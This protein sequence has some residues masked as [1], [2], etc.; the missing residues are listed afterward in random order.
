MADSLS[1]FFGRQPE[2][3]LDDC[4]REAIH[5]SC[6]VQDV[7]G[8]IAVQPGTLL[9]VAASSGAQETLRPYGP[10]LVGANLLDVHAGLHAR[11]LE[12]D[13]ES[14]ALHHT[15]DGTFSRKGAPLEC[16][17][18]MGQGQ[19][20]L[21]FIPCKDLSVQ[22]LRSHLRRTSEGAAR[23]ANATDLPEAAQLACECIRELTDFTRVDVYRFHSDWSG[24]VIGESKAD[25]MPGF[26]GLHFPATDIPKQ[27]RELYS[28]VPFRGIA[29]T[30]DRVDPIHQHKVHA[31]EPIDLSRSLIRSA[32][33][34]HTAY[35]RN[36]GV[37]S[38]FSLAVMHEGKLWG[39]LACHSDKPGL[40][41]FDAWSLA[42]DI[43]SSLAAYLKQDALLRTAKKIIELRDVERTLSDALA[44]NHE[45]E[46]ALNHVAPKL[47]KMLNATG[48]AFMYGGKIQMAGQTPPP[49]FITELITWLPDNTDQ[50]QTF[51]TT[52]LHEL[53]PPAKEHMSTACGVL[54]HPVRP[55]RAYYMI[56]FRA[57]HAE[58]VS[59]AGKPEDKAAG[60]SPGSL[61]SLRPRESFSAW[62]AEHNSA[63]AEWTE[64]EQKAASDC[65]REI[66]IIVA[67]LLSLGEENAMLRAFSVAAAHDI[68]GPLRGINYALSVMADEDFDPGAVKEIHDIAVLSTTR[69]ADLTSSMVE[70]TSLT[71]ESIGTAAVDLEQ[72]VEN[73]RGLL[74]VDIRESGAEIHVEPLPRVAGEQPLLT[75]LLL[76]LI[77]N[78]IK[79]RRKDQ[80]PRIHVSG[81]VLADSMVE[82]RVQDNGMGIPE[83]SIESVFRPLVRLHAKAEIEGTGL[84]LAI[85]RRIAEL[86]GGTIRALPDTDQGATFAVR[87]PGAAG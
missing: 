82:I 50:E 66:L 35:L 36:M 18:H 81:K 48:F 73:I 42:R 53:W 45:L 43:G 77:G 17:A 72:A 56:W 22:T 28:I 11:L 52:E 76:N 64:I 33:P 1:E 86:H 68:K 40:P 58:T 59:W 7:G 49:D 21:E 83:A 44:D 34:M 41:P 5:L 23:I 15:L 32:S 19:W 67:E 80:A 69:L 6:A 74:L 25:H 24:E 85:C 61:D 62:H 9:V 70:L 29:S 10:E 55:N 46:S 54:V 8:L 37:E 31:P 13:E 12:L 14:R 27:A 65:L 63:T 38:S 75:S 71:S 39:L 4:D 3:T 47:L 2:A 60:N 57:P 20:I 84:G 26:L 79:F 87:L 78:A 51:C 16:I 30:D